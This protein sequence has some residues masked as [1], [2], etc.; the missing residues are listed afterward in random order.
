[1]KKLLIR[2]ITIL[3]VILIGITG[4]K[5]VSIGKLNVLGILQIKQENEEL[6][7]IIEE[8]TKLA[9]TDYKNA[10]SDVES[11]AKEL[12]NTKEEYESM[13]TVSTDSEV[14]AAN[15]TYFYD[16]DMLWT[17]IGNHAKTEGVTIDI[18]V[19]NAKEFDSS[20]TTSLTDKKY[21]CDLSFTAVGSY[22]GIEEFITDI[23][24]DSE[25][26]FKIE[27][28]KMIPSSEKTSVV[29]ATF[30][31]TSIKIRG[32]SSASS[33]STATDEN[34]TNTIDTNTVDANT[35]TNT[36]NTVQ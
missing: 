5:G 24:D 17:K 31:C 33:S 1:M 13:V 30:D 20:D 27:N 7:E 22:V 26:G 28:F 12:A 2:V 35:T 32:I 4:V 6:D 29:E 19:K 10:Q 3:L 9:S 18:V 14:Q 15:Q 25:L 11:A 21:I 16:I 8:A 36:T 34:T 23:E